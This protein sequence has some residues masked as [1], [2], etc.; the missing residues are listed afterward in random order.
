MG[1]LVAVCLVLEHSEHP[2]C[3]YVEHSHVVASQEYEVFD[4]L[5]LSEIDSPLL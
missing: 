4:E 3:L 5:G 2:Y 1:V